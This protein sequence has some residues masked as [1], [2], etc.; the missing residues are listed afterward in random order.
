MRATVNTSVSVGKADS[1]SAK[2]GVPVYIDAVGYENCDWGPAPDD[3]CCTVPICDKPNKKNTPEDPD[4]EPF[5]VSE[6][7]KVY[8]IGQ[9]WDTGTKCL[10]KSCQCTLLPNG[11]TEAQCKGGCASLPANAQQPSVECPAPQIVQPDDPCICP[12]VICHN[13]MNR[14]LTD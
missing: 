5:C 14:E 3:P 9:S 1:E 13:N 8:K 7:G 4:A 12:Y 10:K 11:T 6:G 2:R